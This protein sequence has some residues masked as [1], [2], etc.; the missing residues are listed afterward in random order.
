MRAKLVNENLMTYL[1]EVNESKNFIDPSK[2]KQLEKL[3]SK[4]KLNFVK[5]FYKKNKNKFLISYDAEMDDISIMSKP[6]R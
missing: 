4:Y 1:E 2:I 5:K 6:K 3:L